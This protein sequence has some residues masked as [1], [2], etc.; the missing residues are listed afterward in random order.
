M[1]GGTELDGGSLGLGVAGGTELD[2]GSLGLGV[3]GGTELD[4]SAEGVAV[5][6]GV[7]LTVVTAVGVV[8]PRCVAGWS[9]G[10]GSRVALG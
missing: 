2:G 10:R 1:A 4:G 7:A 6:L 8:V 9:A 5:G 3:A